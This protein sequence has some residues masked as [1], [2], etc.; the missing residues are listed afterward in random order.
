MQLMEYMSCMK[1]IRTRIWNPDSLWNPDSRENSFLTNAKALGLDCPTSATPN[2][3][4]ENSS[5]DFG[6]NAMGHTIISISSNLAALPFSRPPQHPSYTIQLGSQPTIG[7]SQFID[8][9]PHLLR[10]PSRYS[11]TTGQ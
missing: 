5:E 10:S 7:V 2:S 1:S 6:I 8:G 4:G 3:T 9:R 11:Y